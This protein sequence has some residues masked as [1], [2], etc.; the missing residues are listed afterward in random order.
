MSILG[1]S[2]NL[3]ITENIIKN[4]ILNDDYRPVLSEDNQEL[5]I[6]SYENK[7]KLDKIYFK[8]I[9]SVHT[10]LEKEYSN[11]NKISN[12][13]N[14]FINDYN[15][16]LSVYD[17]IKKNK[18]WL[19]NWNQF[20]TFRN[21]NNNNIYEENRNNYNNNYIL[22]QNMALFYGFENWYKTCKKNTLT[23]SSSNRTN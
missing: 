22:L 5:S 15:N 9:N 21:N 4:N 6:D 19:N 11:S 8:Y 14:K 16:I 17:N 12:K 18:F 3:N 10:K 20:N 23:T 13:Y 1:E 2:I 7:F